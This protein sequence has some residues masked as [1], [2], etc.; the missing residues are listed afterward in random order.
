VNYTT[1]VRLSVSPGGKLFARPVRT[2]K[3]A[4]QRRETGCL[5][6]CTL[7]HPDAVQTQDT[8]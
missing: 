6:R 1:A 7:T 3:R 2:L 8:V 4:W 5:L